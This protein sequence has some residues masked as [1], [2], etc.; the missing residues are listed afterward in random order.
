MFWIAAKSI[1]AACRR[2]GLCRS[3]RDFSRRLLGRGPH[4]MRLV[5]NR[6]G[7]VSEN[8]TR[9][10]RRRLGERA[11]DEGIASQDLCPILLEIARAEEM[12]RWL[13]R[14]QR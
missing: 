2:L 3:Q 12:S 9:A 14:T 7:F 10:L 5:S 13:R 11:Q 4:Y 8:A 6:K 1:Y